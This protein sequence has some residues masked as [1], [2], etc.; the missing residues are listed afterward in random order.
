[1]SRVIAATNFGVVGSVHLVN[2]TG[3]VDGYLQTILS[4]KGEPTTADPD[5]TTAAVIPALTFSSSASLATALLR[6]PMIQ[7]VLKQACSVEQAVV[8]VGT[9]T[10]DAT[11]VQL[12]FLRADDVRT[13]R[14]RCVVGDIL[15]QFFDADGKVVD[16]PIHDRRI[17]IQLSDLRGIPKVAGVARGL[18]EV[19]AILGALH[20][21]FLDILVTNEVAAIRLLELECSSRTPSSTAV[22]RLQ[23]GSG[24]GTAR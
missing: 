16:L 19:E 21:G 18:H 7:Q 11:I 12:G 10:T 4:S 6:A 23:R 20:G 8:G 22:P 15:G 13:L 1:V 3:R 24:A 2:L 17:R 5:L 14:E 9:P